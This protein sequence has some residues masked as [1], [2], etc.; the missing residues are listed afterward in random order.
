MGT[1]TEDHDYLRLLFARVGTPIALAR[2]PAA[3]PERSRRWW[4]PRWRC[5][6]HAGD[7]A[8]ARRSCASARGVRRFFDDMQT[9]RASCTFPHRRRDR[10]GGTTHSGRRRSTRSTSWCDQ[11]KVRVD[12]PNGGS[13]SR[14]R[15]RAKR[16]RPRA[17]A[18]HRQH[19]QETLFST[20]SPA[21]CAT[22][23]W[24]SS[25][26]CSLVQQPDRRVRRATASGPSAD[27]SMRNA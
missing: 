4:T 25:P 26:G 17:A 23:L 8:R 5:R 10:R 11:L 13:P 27:S 16:R 19:G 18:R 21:R 22:S 6:G 9:C 3:V 7:G 15:R 24:N 20:A 2:P 1:V 12:A 14:S